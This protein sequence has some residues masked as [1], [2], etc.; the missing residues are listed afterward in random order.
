MEFSGFE[1]LEFSSWLAWLDYSQHLLGMFCNKAYRYLL[2]NGD[3]LLP[4][5]YIS[6]VFM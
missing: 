4:I 6:I 3:I 1:G 5:E 2:V